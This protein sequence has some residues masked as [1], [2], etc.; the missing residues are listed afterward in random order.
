MYSSSGWQE[1]QDSWQAVRQSGRPGFEQAPWWGWLLF[2]SGLRDRLSLDLFP[3]LHH[4]PGCT[5]EELSEGWPP[6]TKSVGY[7]R[8]CWL[9]ILSR[10][11]LN[12]SFWSQ[13]RRSLVWLDGLLGPLHL[14]CNQ[15]RD[16]GIKTAK[17]E[18][19]H[20]Q[21]IPNW[22]AT[23]NNACSLRFSIIYKTDK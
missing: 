9:L 13:K 8:H 6:L 21:I 3:F 23:R 11:S 12:V 1:S 14:L 17:L 22:V 2:S 16:V 10:K 20:P 7:E 4:P 5:A 15:A 19:K 18:W